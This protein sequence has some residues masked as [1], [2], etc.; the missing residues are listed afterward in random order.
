[1]EGHRCLPPGTERGW[2]PARAQLGAGCHP[3]H[4]VWLARVPPRCWCQEQTRA[5]TQHLPAASG[6][7][8]CT[9]A[10]FSWHCIP[11]LWDGGAPGERPWSPMVQVG[12]RRSGCAP[13]PERAGRDVARTS[14]IPV[15]RWRL[16]HPQSPSWQ[17]APVRHGTQGF[18][19]PPRPPLS[20]GA[21]VPQDTGDA[22]CVCW[23]EGEAVG[24]LGGARGWHDV[25]QDLTLPA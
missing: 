5:V 16:I 6:K 18:P 9:A 25:G 17:L 15:A 21:R 20:L 4:G 11:G 24:V 2:H 7:L 19:D 12:G 3:G 8:R 10:A 23:D 1:M 14:S 13:Q 22:S